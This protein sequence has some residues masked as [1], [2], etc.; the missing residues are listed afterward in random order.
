[1]RRW[2]VP[3]G[4]TSGARR[5]ADGQRT[6]PA[7]KWRSSQAGSGETHLSRSASITCLGLPFALSGPYVEKGEKDVKERNEKQVA[8]V[9]LLRCK[10]HLE[11]FDLRSM[12]TFFARP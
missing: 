7:A 9:E 11:F 8:S 1:V 5:C 10:L 3:Q 4:R 6:R 2:R 12:P